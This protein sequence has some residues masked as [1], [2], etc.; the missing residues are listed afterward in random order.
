VRDEIGIKLS[1]LRVVMRPEMKQSTHLETGN[2]AENTK[3]EK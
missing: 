3:I 1:T 2:K